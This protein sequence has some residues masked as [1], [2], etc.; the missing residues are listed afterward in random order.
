MD[1]VDAP[2]AVLFPVMSTT[3]FGGEG[4]HRRFRRWSVAEQ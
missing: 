2:P 3:G 1:P 4:V